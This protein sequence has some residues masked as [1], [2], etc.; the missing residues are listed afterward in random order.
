[1]RKKNLEKN[2]A[3]FQFY[4]IPI[5][6]KLDNLQLPFFQIWV[7]PK[8]LDMQNHGMKKILF[9]V[10]SKQENDQSEL[11]PNYNSSKWEP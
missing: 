6:R 10:S 9:E 4:W 2:N 1:M 7:A 5:F 3:F 11:W 8:L